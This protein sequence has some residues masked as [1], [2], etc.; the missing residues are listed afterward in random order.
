MNVTLNDQQA[1]ELRPL[2]DDFV[3]AQRNLAKAAHLLLAGMGIPK[4][5]WSGRIDDGF[6]GTLVFVLKDD[7]GA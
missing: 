4:D 1:E 5:R 3:L 2:Y 7:D 6:G